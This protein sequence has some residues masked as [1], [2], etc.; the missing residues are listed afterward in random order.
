MARKS[1]DS[2]SPHKNIK[3]RREF[4]DYDYTDKLNKEEREFL[5][6][7]SDEFYGADFKINDTYCLKNEILPLIQT[8]IQEA[9]DE[10]LDTPKSNLKECRKLQRKLSKY[11]NLTKQYTKALKYVKVNNNKNRKDN[12]DL[13][14]LR[15]IDKYYKSSTGRYVTDESLKYDMIHD[16]SQMKDCND[17]SNH[18]KTCISSNWNQDSANEGDNQFLVD[19]KKSKDVGTEDYFILN[20]DIDERIELIRQGLDKVEPE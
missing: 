11:E 12:C 4:I 14:K 9:S 18:M 20:E 1:K 7:F 3:S 16:K 2:F 19:M 8:W 15:N 5:A 10:L 13:R 6:K 17:R